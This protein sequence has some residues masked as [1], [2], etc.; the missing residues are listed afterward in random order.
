MKNNL[1]SFFFL[2]LANTVFLR[3]PA[4]TNF[5]V[6]VYKSNGVAVLEWGIDPKEKIAGYSIYLEEGD[7]SNFPSNK[8]V[9]I[10]SDTDYWVSTERKT[11]KPFQVLFGVDLKDP[12]QWA[13]QTVLT[14]GEIYTM[15]VEKRLIDNRIE[16]SEKLV[17][18]PCNKELITMQDYD[19]SNV[20]QLDI[21]QIETF[22]N[23]IFSSRFIERKGNDI[24]F[25]FNEN[26]NL[27]TQIDESKDFYFLHSGNAAIIKCEKIPD[28]PALYGYKTLIVHILQFQLFCLL[29]LSV[30]CL[31]IA[32]KALHYLNYLAV[33]EN[34]PKEI[35]KNIIL[36]EKFSVFI[37]YA[38][39]LITKNYFSN[40]LIQLVVSEIVATNQEI[41]TGI[42]KIL[43]SHRIYQFAEI[44]NS[45]LV[46]VQ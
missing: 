36:H 44:K 10:D 38:I 5:P 43:N 22:R 25:T 46:Y 1:L 18:I 26:L 20:N 40:K 14:P 12:F 35:I 24:Y 27:I 21:N 15:G 42:A 17:I 41:I 28:R 11:F 3:S 29:I 13:D 23:A 31:Y 6:E 30:Y 4:Q 45:I 34:N 7:I 33:V 32:G 9:D 8:I 16:R 39:V 2:L 19:P 37:I